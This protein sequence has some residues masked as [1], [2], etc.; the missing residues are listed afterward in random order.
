MHEQK[1]PVKLFARSSLQTTAL[2][3][4]KSH[5]HAHH[6]GATPATPRL[7]E[8]RSATLKAVGAVTP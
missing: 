4:K 5:H 7:Q 3:E 1:S 6:G 8:Q 2:S